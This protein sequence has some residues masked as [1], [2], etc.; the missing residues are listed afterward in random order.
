MRR[1]PLNAQT[2]RSVAAV[3]LIL[4]GTFTA[5]AVSRGQEGARL[6][7]GAHAR[8]QWMEATRRHRAVGTVLEL[9]ADSLALSAEPAG[10]R[11]FALARLDR[12]DVLVARSRVRGAARGAGLGA[13]A[14]FAVG[15]AVAAA[16]YTGC[17]GQEM[18]GIQFIAFPPLGALA[19]VTLGTAAGAASPGERWQGVRPRE[20][21][22]A[23]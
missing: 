23:R 11:M 8:V 13:L 12:I 15:L 10:A 18:C 14:G 1:I 3:L 17:R 4:T 21:G 16:S 22:R 9:R 5:P 2:P 20:L 19:G 7:S 6:A